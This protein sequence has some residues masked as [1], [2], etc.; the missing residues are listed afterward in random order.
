MGMNRLRKRSGFNEY[1]HWGGWGVGEE[2]WAWKM[3]IY[4]VKDGMGGEVMMSDKYDVVKV[5]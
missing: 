4:V 3:G 2:V 5:P 1:M